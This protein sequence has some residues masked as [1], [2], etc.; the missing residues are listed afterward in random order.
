MQ[1]DEY[2]REIDRT[3]TKIYSRNKS[4]VACPSPFN[5]DQV[6]IVGL[7]GPVFGVI[8]AQIVP[9][10]TYPEAGE[11]PFGVFF[12]PNEFHKKS[13]ITFEGIRRAFG[14]TIEQIW[15]KLTGIKT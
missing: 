5:S 15:T 8:L 10:P 2:I 12:P 13:L 6:V 11:K 9:D 4:L 14:M 3:Q 1:N 7:K